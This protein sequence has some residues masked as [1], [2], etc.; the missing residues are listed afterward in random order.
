[1]HCHQNNSMDRYWIIPVDRRI[2]DSR[3]TENDYQ[4]ADYQLLTACSAYKT[5]SLFERN[6]VIIWECSAAPNCSNFMFPII[7]IMYWK[8]CQSEWLLEC[9]FLWLLNRIEWIEKRGLSPYQSEYQGGT[10]KRVDWTS[11]RILRLC[12]Y[13]CRLVAFAKFIYK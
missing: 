3:S 9:R 11:G 1:M 6:C 5:T 13:Y 8:M 7:R 10:W 4:G 12:L 2:S